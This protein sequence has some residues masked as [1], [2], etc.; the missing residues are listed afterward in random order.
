M[1]RPSL[2][3]AAILSAALTLPAPAQTLDVPIRPPCNQATTEA[4]CT[5]VGTVMGLDPNGDGFLSVRTG[6]GTAFQKIGELRNGDRV[7]TIDGQDG[8]LGVE[9]GGGRLGWVHGNWIGNRIP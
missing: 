6:P 7:T 1:S 3:A 9:Y 4:A 8:W 2:S 5:G